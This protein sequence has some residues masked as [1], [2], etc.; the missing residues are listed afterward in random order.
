MVFSIDETTL[1]K[2][3]SILSAYQEMF[4]SVSLHLKPT[5]SGDFL[6]TQAKGSTAKTKKKG[7][8]RQPCLMPLLEAKDY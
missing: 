4:P 3:T 2:Y 1:L 8:K 6:L 7:D 5:I